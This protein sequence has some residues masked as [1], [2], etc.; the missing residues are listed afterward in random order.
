MSMFWAA[1][2]IVGVLVVI[3]MAYW[4]ILIAMYVE[5]LRT[6]EVHTLVT[7]D[8]WKLRLCRYRKGRTEGEP[9]LFVHGFNANQNNFLCPED[10]SMLEYFRE[11]GYDCWTIDLRGTRS[12]VPAFEKSIADVGLD[13]YLLRDLPDAIQYIRRTTGYGKIHWVGHSLG[14]LLLYAYELEHG[15]DTIASGITLGAPIAF[16]GATAHIPA[17]V[18]AFARLFPAAAGNLLRGLVPIAR[19]LHAGLAL[20]PINIHNIHPKMNT[21]HFVSMLE[22]PPPKVLAEMAF[23]LKHK[24]FR[25]KNDQLDVAA[26]LSNLRVPLLAIFATRDPFAP[27][28]R[29]QEF[30]DALPHNDKRL[31][32]LSREN[33]CAGDYGHCD[34]AFSREGAHEVF[35]PMLQWIEAHPSH[36]RISSVSHEEG[37]SGYRAPLSED[38]RARI[39]S[40]KSYS[41]LTAR[42]PA[43]KKTPPKKPATKAAPKKTA[44]APK[45]AAAKKAAVP[46]KL[47]AKKS[48]AKN[49]KR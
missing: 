47:V 10:F 39:L 28:A 3:L 8:L 19:F 23:C 16:E 42:R 37:D 18:T 41:H 15:I 11:R 27:P 36:E 13:D 40:G 17:T 33:G 49:K 32:I 43:A 21:G 46:K 7:R 45:K 25:L 29:G 38:Q 31:L 44:P 48:A 14:G 6:N 20:F 9:I 4:A 34:L 30:F 1:L 22:N 24:V 12:S 5:N 26:S 35:E 2:G